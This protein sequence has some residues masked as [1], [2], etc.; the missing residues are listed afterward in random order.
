MIT[1][2]FKESSEKIY[3]FLGNI[4]FNLRTAHL[5]I[6]SHIRYLYFGSIDTNFKI[7]NVYSSVLTAKAGPKQFSVAF[8]SC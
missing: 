8:Q 5:K 4:F 3:S 7:V 6:N 1:G 2:E